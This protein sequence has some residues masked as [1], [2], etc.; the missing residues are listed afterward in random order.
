[1]RIPPYYRKPAWQQLF[2]GMAIGGAVSWFIFLFIFGVWQE[3]YSFKIEKQEET[4]AGL[5]NDIKL[6]QESFKEQNK[7][8]LKQMTVQDIKVKITN[9]DKYKLD[10]LSVLQV[11]DSVKEDIRILVAKDMESV[12]KSTGLIRK[13]IENRTFRINDKR[14]RLEVSEMVIFTTLTISLKISF[15]D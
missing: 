5:R 10:T 14:Y 1:M 15:E 6:W 8:S 12:S 2:A 9:A 3:D 7:K 4:I 13:V 11:E